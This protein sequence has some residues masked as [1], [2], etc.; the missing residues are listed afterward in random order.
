MPKRDYH[1]YTVYI[2]TNRKLDVLYVGMTAGLDDTMER[3]MAGKGS[4][5]SSKYNLKLLVYY[6][7]FQYVND[8]IKREKQLKNWYRQWKIN[9]IE[10]ENPN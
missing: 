6:E 7:D 10:Q 8:A 5:F 1:N 3:H 4:K 2:I 9:L